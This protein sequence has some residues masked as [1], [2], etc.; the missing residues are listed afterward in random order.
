VPDIAGPGTADRGQLV[1]R[2]KNIFSQ[3]IQTLFA[4]RALVLAYLAVSFA[5]SLVGLRFKDDPVYIALYAPFS[6]I[7][8]YYVFRHLMRMR[9][10]E[11][12]I[13]LFLAFALRFVLIM[14]LAA[15]AGVFGLSALFEALPPEVQG[16]DFVALTFAV[17]SMLIVF[18]PPYFLGTALPAPFLGIKAKVQKAFGRSLRQTRYLLPRFVALLMPAMVLEGFLA[19]V[20]DMAGPDF[21]PIDYSGDINTLSLL[22][23]VVSN[24]IGVIAEAIFMVIVTHAYLRDLRERGEIPSVDADVFS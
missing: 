20:V 23:L 3:V 8:A 10:G 4:L 11:G 5:I 7:F 1:I 17:L 21:M 2:P 22:L 6:A 15:F 18:A 14:H 12:S 19:A 9:R 16:R 24:V 13:R